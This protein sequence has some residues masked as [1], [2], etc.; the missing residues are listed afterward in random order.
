MSKEYPTPGELFSLEGDV[1]VVTG[2]GRGI[3]EGIARTL[4]SAGAKVVVAARRVHEIEAVAAAIRAD[5]GQAIAVETDVTSDEAMENL[6]KA[7]IKEFGK[8]SIWINNAG[9]S[10]A[11]LPMTDL[12]R[13]DW[14]GDDGDRPLSHVGQL[15]AKRL[16]PLYFPY[17]IKEIHSSD[18]MRCI[19]TIEPMARTIQLNPIFSTDLSEYRY[20]KDKEAA[21]DYAQDL[22]TRGVAGIICSHNPILPKLLKKLIGK[23]NFKQLDGKLEPGDSWVLHHRDGEI[24][25]IDSV[26]RP[27][28]KA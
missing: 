28:V 23:K 26:E 1:A 25:A 21:L 4:A 18:A 14:D 13:E 12:K 11:R 17:A 22:L 2:G 19:E 9:G 5:G 8:L 20:A 6:A 7:A 27:E 10:P 15:Q 24:I 3:G 16:F